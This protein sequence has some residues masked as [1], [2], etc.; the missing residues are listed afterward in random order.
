MVSSG[1]F[2]SSLLSSL[3]SDLDLEIENVTVGKLIE[4]FVMLLFVLLKRPPMMGMFARL[5]PPMNLSS[6]SSRPFPPLQKW[7]YCI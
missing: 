2:K 4:G 7:V 6:L 3:E 5:K 1:M